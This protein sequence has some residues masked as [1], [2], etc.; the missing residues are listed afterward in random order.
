MK[1]IVYKTTNLINNYIYIGV[2]KTKNEN[3]FDGYL[4]NGI[5]IKIPYSYKYS[6]TKF[7]QAVGEF[8]IKNFRRETLGIYDTAEE[9]SELEK[10]LVNKDFLKRE[11]VYNMISGGFSE[12]IYITTYQYNEKGEFIKEFKSYEDAARDL[13]VNPTCIRRSVLYK[14]KI[15]NNFFTN[16]FLDKLDLSTYTNNVKKVNIFKYLKTG[17]YDKEYISYGEA[18]RDNETSPSN[19]LNAC[20]LGYCVKDSFYFS[21]IKSTSF[22]DAR[23]KQIDNREVHKYSINGDYIESYNTQKEAE[24]LN[25]YSNITKSIKL[26]SVDEN[27]FMWGLE[28]LEKYNCKTPKNRIKKV[29]KYDNNGNLVKE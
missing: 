5:N 8:G 1:Y 7:Q 20:I 22:D 27:N 10:L 17:E 11:D 18:G 24:K 12:K 21:Y 13:Q 9:A 28:K 3:I 23:K 2:H 29:G 25:K 6:K 4:G 15:K 14:Y 26:K 19:I 16:I